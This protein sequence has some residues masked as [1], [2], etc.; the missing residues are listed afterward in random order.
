MNDQRHIILRDDLLINHG[1]LRLCYLH[2]TDPGTVVKLPAGPG[3]HQ[4]RANAIE[5]RGYL[6]LLKRHGQLPCISH[7][8]G[9]AMTNLGQ[10][11]LCECVRDDDGTIARTIWDL[12]VGQD[13]YDVNDILHVAEEFCAYLVERDVWLFDLNTKNIAMARQRGGGYRP[14]LLDLK[15]RFGNNEFLPIS[16]YVGFLARRKMARRIRQ[17]LQRIVTFHD[18]RGRLREGS[19]IAPPP[20][21]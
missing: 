6:D 1:Q 8:R 3:R 13:D 15:G 7:C 17:L 18:N 14:V 12:I 5:Y 4:Q 16:S 20:G 9:F 11:L 2:P 19:A 10:G 21:T